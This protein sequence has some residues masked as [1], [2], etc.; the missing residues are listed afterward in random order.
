[1]TLAINDLYRIDGNMAT[2]PRDY[3]KVCGYQVFNVTCK[4]FHGIT[5]NCTHFLLSRY[6][7]VIYF[8]AILDFETLKLYVLSFDLNQICT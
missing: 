6:L 8:E 7:Y 4:A 3:S 1:M 5:L 2:N